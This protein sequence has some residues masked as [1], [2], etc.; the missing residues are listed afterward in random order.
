MNY[1]KKA[2]TSNL[3]HF[4]KVLKTLA[5]KGLNEKKK[6]FNKSNE[7]NISI[8][9]FNFNYLDKIYNNKNFAIFFASLNLLYIF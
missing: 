9:N 4:Q 1:T 6:N 3:K 2:L 8:Q 5:V 7:V